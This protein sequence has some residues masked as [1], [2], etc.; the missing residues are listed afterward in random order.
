V[1]QI[2]LVIL[3]VLALVACGGQSIGAQPTAAPPAATASPTAAA[4]AAPT[5]EAGA[6]P[7][8]AATAG[9]T[10]TAQKLRTPQEAALAAAGGQQLG[11]AVTVL[12]TWGG[13]EQDSFLAMVAP[14]EEAT[15]VDVQY[16]GTRDLN[17][18]L[19]T[20]VQGGNPPDLA[21]LPGQMAEFAQQD[22]LVDLGG[23]IDLD[24]YKQQYAQNWIDLGTVDGKLVGI[25][26]KA[27]AKGLIWHNPD[28]W[29]QNN[30]QT[31]ENWEQLAQLSRQMA[32]TG[33]TP[34]CVGLESGAASG[35]TGTDWIEDI[36]LRQAGPEKY[37]QWY[38]GELAWT[39]PEIKGAWET[40]G[41]IVGDAEMV[42]GGP[43]TMLTTNFQVAGNP[44]FANPPGC[45]MHHQASFITD[46][47]VQNNPNAQPSEDFSF[48]PF[49]PIG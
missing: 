19:T 4:T 40:W 28:V 21:G 48:F 14:F 33:T 41:Q 10:V 23:V 44:L 20:R 8:A 9:P 26:I 15:G 18:V 16:E 38:Q 42:Y 17:A 2:A 3:T 24:T 11:G 47:Y 27:A 6:T 12:G 43:N 30:F 29:L 31:P 34:W 36:V 22:K 39:S 35:W 37:D 49:P 13:S 5:V 32:E 45:Y 7:G 25:F 1:V 46:F